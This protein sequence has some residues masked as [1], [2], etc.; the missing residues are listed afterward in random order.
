[1]LWELQP[2]AISLAQGQRHPGHSESCSGE[3]SMTARSRQSH[4]QSCCPWAS[5]EASLSPEPAVGFPTP[6][7]VRQ[8]AVR[9]FKPTGNL[10]LQLGP[11]LRNTESMGFRCLAT[12]EHLSPLALGAWLRVHG[13]QVPG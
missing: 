6:T 3:G 11:L 9:A 7:S 5:T 8:T 13:L 2:A 12:Q 4:G 10:T 1:M